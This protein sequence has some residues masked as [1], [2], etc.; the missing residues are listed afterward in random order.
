MCTTTLKFNNTPLNARTIGRR[1]GAIK[2]GPTCRL[3]Q[4]FSPTCRRLFDLSLHMRGTDVT[5]SETPIG[6]KTVTS[7]RYERPNRFKFGTYVEGSCRY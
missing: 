4:H 5:R 1:K 2:R 3:K 7:F 6:F